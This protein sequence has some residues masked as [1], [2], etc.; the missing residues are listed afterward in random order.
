MMD[1][2]MNTLLLKAEEV[3]NGQK[4]IGYQDFSEDEYSLM[5]DYAGGLTDNI[6]KKY[7]KLVFVTLVEITKRWKQADT[8]E[9]EKDNCSYWSYVFKNLFASADIKQQI[10]KQYWNIIDSLEDNY[11]IPIVNDG[12]HYYATL[13][14]HAF[15]PKNSIFSFFDLCYNIYIKDFD[16]GFTK[17]DEEHCHDVAKQIANFLKHEYQENKKVSIGSSAYSIKIG[18][19]SFALNKDLF[20]DF[21]Q[22]I[23]NT[24]YHINKLFYSEPL[25]ESTRLERYIVEWWKNKSKSENISGDTIQRK[26]VPTV[27][28]ENIIVKYIRVEDVVYLSIPP[29]RLDDEN[30]LVGLNIYVEGKQVHSEK[31]KTKRGELII[32]TKPIE[33]ELNSLLKDSDIINVQL[34]IK[35]NQTVIFDSERNKATSLNREFILFEDEKEVLSQINKPTNYFVYS[36]DIDALKSVPDELTRYGTNLYN[37]YPKAGEILSGEI[38]KVDF[39][40]NTKVANLG[41]NACLIGNLLDVEWFL[42][43]ISCIVYTNSV[44]LMIPENTNLKALE[45]RINKKA[46]KLHEVKYEQIDSGCYQFGLKTMGLISESDPTEISLYSYEKEAIILTET[47]II[48][49]NLDIKFNHSF[50]YDDIER[51]VIINNEE[52]TWSREDNEIKYP[53]NDGL[54]LIKIPHFRWTIDCKKEWYVK[55]I[56]KKLW[57]KEILENESLLE[58]ENQT[59][60][61]EIKIYGRADD[62]RFEVLKNYRGQYEIGKE[63]YANEGKRDISIYCSYLSKEL[64]LFSVATKKYF[65][66]NPLSYTNGKVFWNAEN[67]FLGDK[68]SEF[69]VIVKDY[70]TNELIRRKLG[71]D[72]QV[73]EFDAIKEDIYKII[74]KIKV[75]NIFITENNYEP[76]FEDNLMIGKAE[77]FRFRNKKIRITKVSTDISSRDINNWIRPNARYFIRDIQ[78]EDALSQNENFSRY[79]GR[80]SVMDEE[81][82]II[83]LDSMVNEYDELDKINPVEIEFRSNNS[84]WLK[85]GDDKEQLIFDTKVN[86]L[87]YI[88][89]KDQER[90][91]VVNLYKFREEYV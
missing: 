1:K 57:Y 69:L 30:S 31:I 3:F 34:E 72:E 38:K 14:M 43:E 58:I 15:A 33:L 49:P 11:N 19:R 83:Y 62:K 37:I 53:I 21:I 86:K 13:L 42:D 50:Y 39:A 75:K 85:T 65:I 10:R 59:E 24:F 28:K 17:E 82:N 48:L 9:H 46:Y 87:C 2:N 54:L 35:E 5:V 64:Y 90:Y 8:P 22:F 89:S 26:R 80:L 68:E 51:K 20:D 44:E 16:F 23:I 76:I 78:Y 71:R 29:I 60:D 88:N 67:S 12:Q 36:K 7:Y 4:L 56:N 63:I 55:P 32:K 77:K 73:K 41:K 74:V 25:N 91:K 52:L 45:L 79:V 61:K 40:D 27:S 81:D 84:F 6:D 66:E 70:N 47:I 18:L